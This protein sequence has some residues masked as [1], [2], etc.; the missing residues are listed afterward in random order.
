MVRF[1]RLPT[2]EE[3]AGAVLLGKRLVVIEGTTGAVVA[4]PAGGALAQVAELPDRLTSAA[5]FTAGSDVLVVGGEHGSKP[6]DEILQVRLAAAKLVPAGRFT[7]PLAEAGVVPQHG[8][9]YLVGGWTGEKYATAV[10][11]F[12]PP[13]QV[14]LV[15]RLPEGVRAPAVALVGTRLYVAGGLTQAGRSRK[16][17]TVD[18]RSGAVTL[19]GELPQAVDRAVLVVSGSKLYLLGGRSATGKPVDT[20][21]RIDPRT[22]RITP[23]GRMPAPLAGA[24]AVPF[25][26]QTLIVG[27]PSGSVYR[28]G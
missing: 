24:T 22:G 11:R 7:E 6:T 16:V 18:T 23:A 21:V 10:I 26:R 15:A 9:V 27:A 13:N 2:G 12:A 17:F 3:V 1:G 28:V 4:G 5:A 25:G 20:I 19:L 14:T 8:S